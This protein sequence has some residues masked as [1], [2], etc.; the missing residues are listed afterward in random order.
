[1]QY[2]KGDEWAFCMVLGIDTT[3]EVLRVTRHALDRTT[4]RIHNPM[5]I[6]Q[7]NNHKLALGILLLARSAVRSISVQELN[8]KGVQNTLMSESSPRYVYDYCTERF[9]ILPDDNKTLITS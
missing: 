3:S 1:M 5:W 2:V 6:L 9:L 8:Q 7:L 4:D